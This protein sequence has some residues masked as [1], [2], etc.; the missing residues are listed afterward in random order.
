[1]KR[2]YH[3]Y[4]RLEEFRDGMWRNVRGDERWPLVNAAAALMRDAPAFKTAM[5]RAVREWPVSC[6]HNL[7]ASSVNRIAWLGH[8]GCCLAAQSP[9]DLTR[10][11]WHTLNQA[12]QDEANRVAAEALN[13]WE[14][15][16]AGQA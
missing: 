11:A 14:S 2:V 16:Y 15:A 8:A 3:H 1:V 10:L 4:E 12:E 5:L 9:E 7:T 6:E 13:E